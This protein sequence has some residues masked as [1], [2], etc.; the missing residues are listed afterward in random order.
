MIEN[1]INFT[2]FAV[3]HGWQKELSVKTFPISLYAPF[4]RCSLLN[5]DL[6]VIIFLL[7]RGIK[8]NLNIACFIF[9]EIG[10]SNRSVV[11]YLYY[12]NINFI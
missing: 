2:L 6:D 4:S 10:S 8:N 9:D 5:G 11:N 1:K 7:E 12:K 3:Y